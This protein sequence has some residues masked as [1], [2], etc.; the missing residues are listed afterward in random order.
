MNS[1]H[2]LKNKQQDVKFLKRY[3]VNYSNIIP[4]KICCLD[5]ELKEQNININTSLNNDTFYG[6][7]NKIKELFLKIRGINTLYRKYLIYD[8]I[9]FI[10]NKFILFIIII[11]IIYLVLEWQD[12]C[13]N[14]DAIKNRKNLIYAL[15]TSGGKTL[16]A[17]ILMLQEL[18]CNKKNAIFILPFVAIV[19]EK[20]SINTMQCNKIY[21]LIII[22]NNYYNN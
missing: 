12:D 6:L 7:S 14:L 1:I 9:K 17:E 22:Y 21:L 11:S 13:L 18:I 2:L 16:V 5:N 15:P 19:Q 20:V 8:K 3:S 10:I 4:N